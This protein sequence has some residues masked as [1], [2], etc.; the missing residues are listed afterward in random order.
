MGANFSRI[1]NLRGNPPHSKMDGTIFVPTQQLPH[2]STEA[3]S[4]IFLHRSMSSY[5]LPQR[6]DRVVRMARFGG[7]VTRFAIESIVE[8]SVGSTVPHQHVQVSLLCNPAARLS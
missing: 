3:S 2:L 1:L 8:H 7:T 6:W 4:I 5:V